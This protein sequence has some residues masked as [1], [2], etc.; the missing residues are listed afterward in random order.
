MNVLTDTPTQLS[1]KKFM[2]KQSILD[3]RNNTNECTI[4]EITEDE[5]I[6]VEDETIR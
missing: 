3:Y 1:G 5:L 4:V 2:I 6:I